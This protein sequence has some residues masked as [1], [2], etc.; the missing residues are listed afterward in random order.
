MECCA[1]GLCQRN[2]SG[3]GKPNTGQAS[4][5]M[6]DGNVDYNE[7]TR[8]RIEANEMKCYDVC[9]HAKTRLGTETSE[10]QR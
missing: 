8:K 1:T 9:G 3:I 7:E 10:E 5:A 4:D 2:R 6:W